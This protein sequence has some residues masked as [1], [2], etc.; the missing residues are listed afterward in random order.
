M[1]TATLPPPAPADSARR[2]AV[3][4]RRERIALQAAHLEDA[5]PRD[6]LAWALDTHGD[7]LLATTALGAG[8]VL[9]LH[10]LHRLAPGHPTY[11]IDTGKLFDET[12]AYRDY[13]IAAF[14]FRIV[15]V[16][17]ALDE[18]A[19]A[20]QHGETL[21]ETDPD[22]CCR[23][24]KVEPAAALKRE[25]DAWVSALRRDQGGLRATLPA[26]EV[27]RDGVVKV[28]PLINVT[29]AQI[30]GQLRDLGILQHPLH[31]HGYLSVG[32]VP[33][34]SPTCG[35]GGGGDNG[36]RAGRWASTGK[37]ECGLH[38]AT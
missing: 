31:R 6:I 27:D 37:T 11:L 38:F 3:L 35:A 26:A 16:A 8:G 23:L 20:A 17:P 15:T 36:E 12:L 13:L 29:R 34:T 30:D 4:S 19:L 7:R 2:R 33:C 22:T 5:T 9:L 14:G 18:A 10:E 24:R 28:Y 1:T 21:W 25:H 32:C